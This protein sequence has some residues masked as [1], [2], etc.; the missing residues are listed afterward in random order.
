MTF[1]SSNQARLAAHLSWVATADRTKRTAPARAAKEAKLIAAIDP[2]GA[3]SES[4]RAKAIQNARTA[5]GLK[6]VAAREAKRAARE[7]QQDDITARAT[8]AGA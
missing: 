8:E 5:W 1:E 4:D 3:M 2:D 7:A 6:Q